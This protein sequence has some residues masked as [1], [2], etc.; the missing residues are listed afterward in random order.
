MSAAALL[1]PRW[2]RKRAALIIAHP[3]HELRAHGWLEAARPITCVLTDGSGGAGE[4]RLESTSRV[5]ASAGATPGPVYGRLSDRAI[6]AALLD[7]DTALFTGLVEE[8][9][10][11]LLDCEIDYVAG[12]AR[13]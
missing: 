5:L 11:A 3:G 8:L 2:S 9:A 4:P 10:Q 6:Y 12:D 13:E 1:D 7:H